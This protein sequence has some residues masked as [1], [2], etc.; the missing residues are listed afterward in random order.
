MNATI[1][2]LQCCS[3]SICISGKA[4]AWSWDCVR[5]RVSA[6]SGRQGQRWPQHE[7]QA[8]SSRPPGDIILLAYLTVEDIQV[9]YLE[10]VQVANHFHHPCHTHYHYDHCLRLHC[11][12]K[13]TG[14]HPLTHLRLNRLVTLL[15]VSLFPILHIGGTILLRSNSNPP[16]VYT[17]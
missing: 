15:G 16:R 7:P 2:L 10:E 14:H 4:W 12:C 1:N 11:S 6:A 5:G 17:S 8:W 13:L 3:H 9:H